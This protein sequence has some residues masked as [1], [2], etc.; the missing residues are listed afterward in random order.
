MVFVESDHVVEQVATAAL[1][2]TLGDTI[3]LRTLLRRLNSIDVHRSYANR[4]FQ[5]IFCVS[6]EDQK[7]RC[8][9]EGKSL[10]Q[11]LHD[12]HAR[13]VLRNVEMQNA[14]SVVADDEETVERTE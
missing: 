14:S 13:G 6:V 11:L 2:P 8:G 12:P 7:A 10:S 4:N 5:A 3:Q 9:I 1:D